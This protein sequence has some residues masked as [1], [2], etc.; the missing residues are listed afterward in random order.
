MTQ[1]PS[2]VDDAQLAEL[3]IARLHTADDDTE[4]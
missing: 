4:A 3:H 2:P 1:A